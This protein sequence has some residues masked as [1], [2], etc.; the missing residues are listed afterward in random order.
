MFWATEQSRWVRYVLIAVGLL[1]L[2]L[3]FPA[4]LFNGWQ[5]YQTALNCPNWP[6]VTG[7]VSSYKEY[8]E[9]HKGQTFFTVFVNYTY[10]VDG[11]RYNGT[12]VSPRASHPQ[13]ERDRIVATYTPGSQPAV[14]YN[15]SDPA[16]SFL[17]PT[18]KPG[19]VLDVIFPFACL[20][21]GALFIGVGW[22]L[23]KKRRTPDDD[24]VPRRHRRR[25]DD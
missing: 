18:P 11:R 17:E 9:R 3:F 22:A 21:V 8:Q 2:L 1:I 7:E 5:N 19:A 13:E 15:P 20:P 25:R 12:R 16:D 10:T 23:R 14:A 4:F 6:K 24:Y